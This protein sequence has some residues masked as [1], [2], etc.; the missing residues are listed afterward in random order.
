[1]KLPL[2]L[3]FPALL[4]GVLVLSLLTACPPR[5]DA[6]ADGITG[7]AG[8][9]DDNDPDVGAAPLVGFVYGDAGAPAVG[10]ETQLAAA[11]AQIEERAA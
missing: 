10:L 9:C 6:D 4:T 8:D 5:D 3:P 1:M 2:P 7:S 11:G